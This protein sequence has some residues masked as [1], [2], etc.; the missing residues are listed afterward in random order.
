[1]TV[2]ENIIDE[3]QY[4]TN[5]G[6]A[7]SASY[8]KNLSTSGADQNLYIR[9]LTGSK[10]FYLKICIYNTVLVELKFFEDT[11]W[12]SPGVELTSTNLNMVN[13][14]PPLHKVYFNAIPSVEGVKIV[15]SV[16]AA[17]G[18]FILP[19]QTDLFDG[20]QVILKPNTEYELHLFNQSGSGGDAGVI[21]SGYEK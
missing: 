9:I 13:G 10:V 12:S 7:F 16:G 17:A 14:N 8:G 4:Q 6:H 18:L 19:G 2:P 15:P 20:T 21:V 1:M 3:F 11:T 5:T